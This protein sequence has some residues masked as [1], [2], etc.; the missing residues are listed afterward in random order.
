MTRIEI[1]KNNYL[2]YLTHHG[3]SVD[4]AF[5]VV[6]KWGNFRNMPEYANHE[7]VRIWV[8]ASAMVLELD[9]ATQ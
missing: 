1:T 9:G 3:R 7:A 2:N 5:T 6:Q 8:E 4:R